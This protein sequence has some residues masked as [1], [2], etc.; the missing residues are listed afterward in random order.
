MLLAGLVALTA[1]SG[2]GGGNENAVTAKNLTYSVNG[3]TYPVRAD[4]TITTASVDKDQYVSQVE[5]VC[6]EAWPVIRK[7]YRE[8]LQWASQHQTRKTRIEHLIHESILAGIDFHIFDGIYG[9]KAPEGE[10]ARIEELIGTLQSAVER[11]GKLHLHTEKQLLGLF[12]EFNRRA[13]QYGVDEC[14]V[15]AAHFKL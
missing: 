7:N 5:R 6:Q 11:G 12:D 1:L 8:D 13:R 3:H 14:L 4:T 9:L 10:G 2:C 15:D